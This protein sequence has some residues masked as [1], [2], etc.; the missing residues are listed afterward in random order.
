MIIPESINIDFEDF[1]K[2]CNFCEAKVENSALYS[3]NEKAMV[4]ATLTCEHINVCR[5]LW[6]RLQEKKNKTDWPW[7]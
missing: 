7:G 6:N 2:E 4:V 3:G 5:K 1:C